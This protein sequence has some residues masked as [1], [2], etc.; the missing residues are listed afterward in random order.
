MK[1]KCF[2]T[3]K[4]ILN[5]FLG[6]FYMYSPYEEKLPPESSFQNNE[7]IHTSYKVLDFE[8]WADKY[9]SNINN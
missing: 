4:R 3:P 1:L 2:V 7:L 9:W 6:K 5:I 8:K